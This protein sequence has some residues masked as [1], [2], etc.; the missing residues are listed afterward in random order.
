MEAIA[1]RVEAIPGRL[2]AIATRAVG[3]ESS[4]LSSWSGRGTSGWS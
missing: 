2:E 4:A 1:T 3:G